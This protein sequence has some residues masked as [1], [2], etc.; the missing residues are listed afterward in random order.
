MSYILQFLVICLLVVLGCAKVTVQGQA[1]RKFIRCT[2]DSVLFNAQLFLVIA[3]VMAVVFPLGGIG[4]GGVL[5]AAGAALGTF[6]FQTCYALALKCGPVSLTV[7][8]VNFSVLFSTVFSILAYNE[9]IFLT[10]LFGIAFLLASMFLSVKKEDGEKGVSKKWVVLALTAMLTNS[11]AAILMKIFVKTLSAEFENSQNTFVVLM[12]IIASAMAF[13]YYFL[14]TVTDK[15]EKNTYGFF[16][17]FAWLY[18]LIIGVVLGIYQKFYM[19]GME[20]IDGAFMFPTYA[21]MQS[22]GMTV[23]GILL[24]KDRLSIRQK[25]G[26]A[27]GIVCV[28]LMNI[29]LVELF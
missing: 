20:Q 21:G 5:L 26:I 4:W 12:Y 11:G 8:I 15:K 7:L 28:V 19:L 10:Q 9:K 2:P 25:I 17:K 3:V 24:F 18:A 22:L 1:S 13:G 14:G 16:N 27:C 23:I 29:R 6:L